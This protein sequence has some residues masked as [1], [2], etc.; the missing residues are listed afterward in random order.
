MVA[1][2]E[3]LAVGVDEVGAFAAEGFAHEE[4]R[5]SGLAEGSGMELVELHVGSA[6]PA[7]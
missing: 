7:R 4:A 5:G 3:A 1:V 6:A 2:H